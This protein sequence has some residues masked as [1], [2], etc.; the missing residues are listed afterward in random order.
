MIGLLNVDKPQGWTSHDIVGRLRRVTGIRKIGHAGTLDPLATGV[1]VVAVGR[2][3][4]LLEYIVGQPKQYTTTVKLGEVTDTYDADGEV[5]ESHQ[6]AVS[7]KEIE[8]VL[9]RF[10]G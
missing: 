4:R 9:P 5:V 2:A 10:L 1:L 8:A 3:T 6:V 7:Q